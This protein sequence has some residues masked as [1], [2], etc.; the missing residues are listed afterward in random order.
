V[1]PS[2]AIAGIEPSVGHGGQLQRL[3]PPDPSA[4]SIAAMTRSVIVP[5]VLRNACTALGTT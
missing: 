2:Q 3:S 4:A 1:R 5:L